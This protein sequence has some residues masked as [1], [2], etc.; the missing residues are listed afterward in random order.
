[1]SGSTFFPNPHDPCPANT[2]LLPSTSPP[3]TQ[4]DI[5]VSCPSQQ[6]QPQP[7]REIEAGGAREQRPRGRT[8]CSRVLVTLASPHS[9][10]QGSFVVLTSW[11]SWN[12]S[13][14]NA[15]VMA[16]RK[17]KTCV[18]VCVCAFSLPPTLSVTPLPLESSYSTQDGSV[19]PSRAY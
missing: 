18:C 3:T 6:Q 16:G 17:E 4:T 13:T 8:S 19:C 11:S 7:A 14:S 5:A 1:M 15:P 10:I 2:R 12:C 9:L